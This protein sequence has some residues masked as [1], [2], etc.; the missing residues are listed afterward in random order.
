MITLVR[1]TKSSHRLPVSALVVLLMGSHVAVL[2]AQNQSASQAASESKHVLQEPAP[3]AIFR[4]F[5]SSSL[6][7]ELR[8]FIAN[9][10][11]WPEMIDDIHSRI[12]EAFRQANV[13]IAFP[14]V[15][16]H[17][18]SIMDALPIVEKPASQ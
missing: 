6:D 17:V 13:E 10:R 16:L 2:W 12:D 15:D 5:G 9:R 8:V 11:L 3:Q 7:F 14:Q 4:G 18:R 1:V